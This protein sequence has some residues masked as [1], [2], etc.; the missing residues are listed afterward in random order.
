MD[1]APP[2]PAASFV[3]ADGAEYPAP[4]AWQTAVLQNAVSETRPTKENIRERAGSGLAIAFLD[5]PHSFVDELRPLW[6]VPI[7]HGVLMWGRDGAI[8]DEPDD[9]V[10][11][12]FQDWDTFLSE[13]NEGYY[14]LP[15][16]PAGAEVPP[17]DIRAPP[18]T[19]IIAP[20]P[21][22]EQ[23]PDERAEERDTEAEQVA[24]RRLDPN[25]EF[26]YGTRVH[27]SFGADN[28]WYGG[29]CAGE[30]AKSKQIIV[31]FDDGEVREF[32]EQELNEQMRTGY[33]KFPPEG[34]ERYGTVEGVSTPAHGMAS[35][36]TF[37]Q[38]SKRVRR[39]SGVLVGKSD[40]QLLGE[41]LYTQ[42]YVCS[43]VFTQPE[44]TETATRRQRGKST[45]GPSQQDRLGF[46]TFRRGD[47]VSYTNVAEDEA[48][49]AWVH[50][51]MY[52]PA[53]AG[54]QGRKCLVLYEP[55]TMV[56]FVQNTPAWVRL[57][58]D[59]ADGFDVDDDERV[60]R[61]S[62]DD[63]LNMLEVAL[64]ACMRS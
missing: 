48:A 51:F 64:C 35:A 9:G 49:L 12:G 56:F 52:K 25:H 41:P 21:E 63:E 57:A 7:E 33:C 42:H 54:A 62:R 15:L 45:G 38:E 5:R 11:S 40:D 1:P 19:E 10:C 3:D 47:I 20:A 6:L 43:S 29:L 36:F 32:T 27:M 17:A 24:E 18:E 14:E 13:W 26:V 28:C 4:P 31:G 44:V 8:I 55:E 60:A 46:H 39:V 37:F 22:L 61:I 50:S 34:S 30:C 16:P 2:P 23:L 59:A 58:A 53:A